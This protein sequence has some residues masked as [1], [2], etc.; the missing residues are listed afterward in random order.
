MQNLKV[1]VVDDEPGI[2]SGVK[3]ILGKFTVSYPFM[4]EDRGFDVH[5]AFTGE[6]AIESIKKDPPDIVL[7]D[8]KLP[9]IQGTEVLDYINKNHREIV[10]MIITSYASLELAVKATEMGAYDFIPKPFTPQELKSSMEK[11][12][13]HLFLQIMT[14]RLNKEGKEV[15]FQF[16]SVLS[17]ELKSPLN[18]VEGY[19]KIMQERQAGDKISDYDQILERSLQRINGMRT[20]IMDLLDLTKIQSDEKEKQF[21]NVNL[22]DVT[23]SA[24]E[25]VS[26]YAIQKD[27]DINLHADEAIYFHADP[28]DMEIVLNNLISNAVK[29]NYKEGKVDVYLQ[30]DADQIEIKV[31]DTG[32]G[33][34]QEDTAK[35]FNE[36]VRIKNEKTKNITGSGLGLSIVK[37]VIDLYKGNIFVDSEPDR[38]STF[39]VILPIDD[40]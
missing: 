18:A 31:A 8:N 15:R 22:L 19:L 34:N 14:Q 32:I 16:L 40:Q 1:L 7:L 39:T 9:G 21:E 36:F 25:T 26:P 20:L 30:K 5:E 35:L 3:R 23:K 12:T 6:D 24:I 37:K 27:V 38:G 28:N 17:H 4:D 2:C 10:V 13:K 29:Y 33:M 11:V